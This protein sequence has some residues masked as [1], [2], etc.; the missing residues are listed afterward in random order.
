MSAS[1]FLRA[2]PVSFAYGLRPTAPFDAEEESSA[3]PPPPHR[4]PRAVPAAEHWQTQLDPSDPYDEL[5]HTDV[6]HGMLGG[7][8]KNVF[9][10]REV[11]KLLLFA[12]VAIGGIMLID[13]SVKLMVALS[14]CS[15]QKLER[16]Q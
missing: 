10:V 6:V 15:K 12:G 16:Q 8:P 5:S 11:T 3:Q 14:G 4:Q 2:A 13:L 7:I 9:K 1:P